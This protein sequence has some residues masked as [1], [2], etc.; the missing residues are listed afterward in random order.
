LILFIGMFTIYKSLHL[1]INEFT[2][3]NYDIYKYKKSI[4][5]VCDHILITNPKQNKLWLIFVK[6]KSTHG[7]V[8]R[9]LH[10]LK[11]HFH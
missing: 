9:K 1:K 8:K 11:F 7:E 2:L 6:L 5:N 4:Q 10:F 3:C